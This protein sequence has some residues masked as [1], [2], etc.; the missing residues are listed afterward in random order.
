MVQALGD[1]VSGRSCSTQKEVVRGIEMALK[2]AEKFKDR[3]EVCVVVPGPGSEFIFHKP[4]YSALS[5]SCI[6]NH[7]NSMLFT[8]SYLQ[9]LLYSQ[10]N[11]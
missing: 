4:D 8:H 5:D 9:W 2:E 3:A 7:F 10:I 1:A 11:L 6:K